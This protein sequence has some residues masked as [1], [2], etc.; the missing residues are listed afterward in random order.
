MTLDLLP[1]IRRDLPSES[2]MSG[3]D[4]TGTTSVTALACM[5]MPSM[6]VSSDGWL[7]GYD[8]TM[9]Q[10]LGQTAQVHPASQRWPVCACPVCVSHLTGGC[11]E[12]DTTMHLL[13]SCVDAA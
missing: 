13:H 8:T 1:K 12:Y 3:S 2:A 4:C 6:C 5:C 11:R 10:C 9:H 7:R